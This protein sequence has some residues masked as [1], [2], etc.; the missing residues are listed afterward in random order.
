MPDVQ[1]RSRDEGLNAWIAGRTAVEHRE[2][3]DV[4]AGPNQLLRDLVGNPAAERIAGYVI[5]PV[6]LDPA[7]GFDDLR[8]DAFQRKRLRGIAAHRIQIDEIE[9][10]VRAQRLRESVEG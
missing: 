7:H 4:L 1:E 9:R 8:R 2:Q 6:R 3:F 10:L 5:G